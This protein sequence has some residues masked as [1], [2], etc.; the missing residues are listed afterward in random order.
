MQKFL[1]WINK[2]HTK[3]W[4]WIEKKIEENGEFGALKVFTVIIV[5]GGVVGVL[6]VE[7]LEMLIAEAFK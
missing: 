2:G 5:V 6:I 4:E 7:A 1:S 3:M